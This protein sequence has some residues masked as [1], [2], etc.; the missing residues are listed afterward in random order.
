MRCVDEEAAKSAAENVARRRDGDARARG[1]G[2]RATGDVARRPSDARAGDMARDDD[3]S[4]DDFE[5]DGAAEDG[6]GDGDGDGARAWDP[7]AER[8]AV[9][10]LI[11]ASPAMFEADATRADGASAFA[12]ATR[13][14]FEFARARAS[15][16]RRTTSWA[17]ARTTRRRAWEG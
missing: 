11:D 17:C 10:M 16:W 12:A 4:D 6:D 14:C 5:F 15:S 7:D 13:A 3:D 2:A 1:G 8:D 9:V